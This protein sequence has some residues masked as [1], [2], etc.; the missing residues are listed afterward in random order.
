MSTPHPI[1]QGLLTRCLENTF[2]RFRQAARATN[3]RL[4]VEGDGLLL[5]A[6]EGLPWIT[7]ATLTRMPDDPA[8]TL[9]RAAAFFAERGLTWGLTAAGE[10]AEAIAPSAAALGLAPGERLPGM[11]LTPLAG[12]VPHVPG[13]AIHAVR[14]TTSLNQFYTTSA[15]GFGEGE[16]L[17]PLVYP[18]LV[19]QRPDLTLYLGFLDGEPVATAVRI[20]CHGIA[21]IGG[22]STVPSARRRGIG[23][24]IT[25][26][27]ALD[28]AAEGCRAS[29]LQASAMGFDLYERM[30]YRHVIDFQTWESRA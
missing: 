30:G 12:D 1:D 28:G 5:I 15:V 23:E 17:F 10:V 18:S 11:A 19:L 29:F 2:E 14:D 4:I 22:V 21:G 24:A 7:G 8:A 3:G 6:A 27:A 20:T 26:R 25:R 13:L 9:R 16:E